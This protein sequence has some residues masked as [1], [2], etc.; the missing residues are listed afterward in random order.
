MILK[1]SDR[2]ENR[3]FP[4]YEIENPSPVLSESGNRW[5]IAL[6]ISIVIAQQ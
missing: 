2:G 3:R 6:W 5:V 1:L 4:F